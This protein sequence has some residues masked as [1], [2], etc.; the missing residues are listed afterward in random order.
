M[1]NF[2]ETPYTISRAPIEEVRIVRCVRAGQLDD[3]QLAPVDV[4]GRKD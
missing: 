3:E 4:L 1:Q 2:W